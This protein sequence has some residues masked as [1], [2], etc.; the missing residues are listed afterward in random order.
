[1]KTQA[2][3]ILLCM[4]L[5]TTS[6]TGCNDINN[7]E[8][9][10]PD[11]FTGNIE[12]EK[13]KKITVESI[14][15]LVKPSGEEI[16]YSI[17]EEFVDYRKFIGAD[18]SVLNV[19]TSE[20]D[21]DEFSQELW[22]STFYGHDGKVSVELGWDDKTIIG[23]FL[24]L[25]DDSKI[26]EGEREELNRRVMDIFG[27]DVEESMTSFEFSGNGDY[28]FK[29]PKTLEQESV[30][31]VTWNNDLRYEYMTDPSRPKPEKPERPE[32]DITFKAPPAI[33]MTAEEV[34]NSTWGKPSDKT[35]TTTRYGVSEQWIYRSYDKTRYIFFED[36]FVTSIVE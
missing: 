29:I 28:S 7:N 9:N 18:I 3:I 33:G 14:G 4:F 31:L 30:C 26:S 10:A 17:P 12:T 21:Y 11:T 23:F 5:I 19:D 20:W 6:L 13:K 34:L 1:M 24:V 22:D 32:I 36:G 2:T 35:K 27:N 15:E 25:D 16:D 8:L